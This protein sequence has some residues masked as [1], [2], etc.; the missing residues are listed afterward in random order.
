MKV[1]CERDRALVLRMSGGNNRY[2][3]LGSRPRME[4]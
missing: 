1:A 3:R 4:G 2:G